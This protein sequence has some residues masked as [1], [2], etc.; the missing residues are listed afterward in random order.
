MLADLLE[1]VDRRSK[2]FLRGSTVIDQEKVCFVTQ[3]CDAGITSTAGFC[4]YTEEQKHPRNSRDG[5]TYGI[6][7]PVQDKKTLIAYLSAM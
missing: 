5:H 2:T 6:T 4:Y 3:P 7:L 1:P